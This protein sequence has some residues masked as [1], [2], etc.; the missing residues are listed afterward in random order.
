MMGSAQA[1]EKVQEGPLMPLHQEPEG[2]LPAF[3][4]PRHQGEIVGFRLDVWGHETAFL[5]Q[6]RPKE[7]PFGGRV[8]GAKNPPNPAR[9]RG[10][11]I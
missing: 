1:G 7:K 4:H 3:A 2:V 9:V 5:A 11:Y 6:S 10:V 8:S